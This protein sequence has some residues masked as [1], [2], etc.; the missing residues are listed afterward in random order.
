MLTINI[1]TTGVNILITAVNVWRLI[2]L[3]NKRI[4][5]LEIKVQDQQEKIM[6]LKEATITGKKNDFVS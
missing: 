5:D 4:A 6:L 3:S 2:C 1:L